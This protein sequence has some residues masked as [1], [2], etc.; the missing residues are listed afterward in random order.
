MKFN[1]QKKI[2]FEN[3]EFS[4]S[5]AMTKTKKT[6]KNEDDATCD[7]KKFTRIIQKKY[8]R[9]QLQINHMLYC[10]VFVM[11][12]NLHLLFYEV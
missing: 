1:H 6:K 10:F 7:K 8:Y 9:Y 2:E 3:E 11:F 5:N 4:H 12:L